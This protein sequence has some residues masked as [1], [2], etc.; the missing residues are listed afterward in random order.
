M[1]V[2]TQGANEAPTCH[3]GL[4]NLEQEY[5]YALTEVEGEIPSNLKGTFFRN[6]PGRQKIGNQPFG[7]WFD[8]D[9]MLCAFTFDN[10][11]EFAFHEEIAKQ[12]G[13]KTYFAPPYHSW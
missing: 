2:Q 5:S 11:K 7:H 3:G 13:A 9:G 1:S 6:G 4:E 12:T 8:G 10:G